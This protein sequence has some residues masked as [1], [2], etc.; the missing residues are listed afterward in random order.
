M[1]KEGIKRQ[2]P[3]AVVIVVVAIG[4][5]GV[6]I[7][8]TVFF[9]G[10]EGDENVAGAVILSTDG[11]MECDADSDLD[12]AAYTNIWDGDDVQ[13]RTRA[14]MA[15]GFSSWSPWASV[16]DACSGSIL[17]EWYCEEAN[18]VS[19]YTSS[20]VTCA[21]G[22]ITASGRGRC[23]L[24]TCTDSDANDGKLPLTS[25]MRLR[26][27]GT[28]TGLMVSDALGASPSQEARRYMDTC[29][30]STSV[31]EYQC[32]NFGV[33]PSG[34]SANR[35]V[36]R[37]TVLCPSDYPNCVKGECVAPS[38]TP[39]L[40]VC[41]NGVDEDCDGADASCPIPTP[42]TSST[43][44]DTDEGNVRDVSGV[45]TST[46]ALAAG[47][48]RTSAEIPGTPVDGGLY[49]YR[50][51]CSADGRTLYQSSCL[52]NDVRQYEYACPP[53]VGS[54]YGFCITDATGSYC[55]SCST[56]P[57]AAGCSSS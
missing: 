36:E 22:C 21:H 15:G 23:H 42:P 30:T 33:V 52:G 18:A 12:T 14:R 10:K 40:E 2:S 6:V 38:C 29:V 47:P 26:T 16:S 17:T 8:S 56:N 24:P 31:Y 5:L 57:A 3:F 55:P 45:A 20:S 53:R 1:R 50:D 32:T 28:T 27:R 11:L 39:S 4:L 54:D 49:E 46:D 44:T 7:Y 9:D 19:A 25:T 41:G 51:S 13:Y 35:R 34:T 37:L 48:T 43:C